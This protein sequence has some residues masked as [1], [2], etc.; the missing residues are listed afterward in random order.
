MRRGK[1]CGLFLIGI[2]T[3]FG[4]AASLKAQETWQVELNRKQ[5][6]SLAKIAAKPGHKAFAV[7]PDGAHGFQWGASSSE[8]ASKD[9]VANCRGFM[10]AGQRD[11][12]LYSVNGRVVAEPVVATR[13][14]S[15]VY[16]PVDGK[17]APAI[18]GRANVN[19]S[20][21]PAAALADFTALKASPA[22]AN[23][24]QHDPALE[25][26]LMQRSFMNT[27]KRAFAIWFE[28]GRGDQ[29]SVGNNGMLRLGFRRWVATP[30]GLVCMFDSVWSTGKTVGTRCLIIHSIASGAAR[31]SWHDMTTIYDGQIIAGDARRGAVR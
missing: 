20:G 6:K 16:K 29:Y 11:C 1:F 19:F 2:L 7:S 5:T 4:S 23:R 17:S 24:L 30:D 26:I 18:F 25:R 27:Q 10:R 28:Q 22:H 3:I 21:N 14:V 15:A 9:A 13:R 12:I 31:F 8:S